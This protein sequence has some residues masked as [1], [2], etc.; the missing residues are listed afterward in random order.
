MESTVKKLKHKQ[1]VFVIEY[2]R[3][4]NATR[5]AIAAGYSKR[6]ARA[7]ASELL[8]NPNIK[9]EIKARIDELTMGADEMLMGLTSQARATLS[10]FFKT[11][12]SL[13]EYPAPT[14]EVLGM[15]KVK[16]EFGIE[17]LM[18]RVRHITI[19][20][21][22]LT[23]PRFAM[24]VKKFSDNKSGLS[25]ELYDKHSAYEMIAKLRGLWVDKTEITGKDGEPIV[26]A[27]INPEL[28]EKLK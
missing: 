11:T 16:D 13:V 9:A 2:T 5:A 7:I 21:D 3:D 8:T 25:I 28:L 12:E 20:L 24:L 1:L 18:Y 23:D 10:D 15:E 6:S 19:D 4:F 22:K 26:I 27:S 14:Q 17:K